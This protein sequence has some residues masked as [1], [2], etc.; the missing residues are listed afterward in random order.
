[1]RVRKT[2]YIMDW[3]EN[4]SMEIKKLTSQGILPVTHDLEMIEKEKGE[5]P[6]DILSSSV[7]YF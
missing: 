6:A 3:E 4:R 5:I 2:A 1:M 7:C